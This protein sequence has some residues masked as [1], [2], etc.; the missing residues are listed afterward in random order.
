[1]T[2]DWISVK[3]ARENNLKD[4]DVKIPRNK[5]T[6]VTG[7]SGSG[8]STLMFN[9]FCQEG[10][11]KFINAMG[12][13]SDK[14]ARPD[15]DEITGLSPIISVSQS[16][17]NFSSRSTVGTY[18]EI[19]TY[20]RLLFA[21]I[22]E[23][24]C[25]K[26]R[27]LISYASVRSAKV[28]M[29][30]S[31]HTSNIKC[32]HCETHIEDITMAHFS[33]NTKV[34][35]CEKCSGMGRIMQPRLDKILDLDLSIN[36]GG[37]KV[38]SKGFVRHFG[39][40]LLKAARHFGLPL[41]NNDL[42][43]PIKEL[44][45]EIHLLLLYGTEDNK[46]LKYFP[47]TDP[48][49]NMT[50]GRYEGAVNSLLRR[51]Y[52]DAEKDEEANNNIATLLE[53]SI[54]PTC[55]GARLKKSILEVLVNSTPIHHV[56]EK[57]IDDLFLWLKDL[58]KNLPEKY[59]DAV[60]PIVTDLLDRS[61]SILEV[62]LGY[63]SLSR[64][65]TSLSGGEAQRLRLAALLNSNLTGVICLLDEPTT[66]LHPCDTDKLLELIKKLR[67]LGNTII[68]IEHDLD[69][70]KK[71][72]YI[73]DIGPY[74]GDNGGEVVFS[75]TVSELIKCKRSLT[76][77]C[78]RNETIEKKEPTSNSKSKNYIE[79]INGNTN[80]LKNVN[81]EIPLNCVSVITGVSG[82]G[83]STL[84]FE[85]LLTRWKRKELLVCGEKEIDKVNVIDQKVMG[86]ASRSNTATYTKVFDEIRKVYHQQS[87]KQGMSMK[88]SY[89]SFNVPGGRCEHCKGVGKVKV[90]MHFM[91]PSYMQCSECKGKRYNQAVLRVKYKSQNIH[92][93]LNMNVK[94]ALQLFNEHP[95]IVKKLECLNDIGLGY[96]KLGQPASTLSGG[97]A[98]RV[99]IAAELSLP[100]TGHVLYILDEPSIGLHDYD[101]KK[102]N[103][104]LHKL[105]SNNNSVIVIEHNLNIIRN[106][107][108][109][110]ELGREGGKNGGNIIAE[111]SPAIIC[112]QEESII[113]KYLY[114]K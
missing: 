106:A 60:M 102:M 98:Q 1:M 42:N 101:T 36:Q 62:G 100:S 39:P 54:C 74:A 29:D 66:G 3:G 50:E 10:Q 37:I 26:C 13:V 69:V 4:I 112:Q 80:N 5:I 52:E 58:K 90:L 87:E 64:E 19:Y 94:Q 110:V 83:K 21:A 93:I 20:L 75:G 23:K 68:L 15:Y 53:P 114:R 95:K 34:G 30:E 11:R 105:V 86:K 82:S 32:P 99:K 79:I 41:S 77:A 109:I 113:K 44:S 47:N 111:G 70:V 104:M 31:D 24:P 84:L 59:L 61:K 78:I 103:R 57:S 8:K 22:G 88:P 45:K 92:D 73:I 9:I 2:L 48:P 71:A 6:V 14:L 18:S 89:F 97:E 96:L 56:I 108:W 16:N 85:E 65:F 38:W 35:A 67:D 51:Y 63:L 107:D 12:R 76:G 49:K 33:F 46:F 7:V 55:K 43:L 25:P 40:L 91:P 28:T 27:K 17:L 72:D 81:V